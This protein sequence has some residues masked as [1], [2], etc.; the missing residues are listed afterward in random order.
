MASQGESSKAGNQGFPGTPRDGAPVEIIGLL[1]SS[2]RWV[3]ELS[4]KGAFPFSGVEATG[5]LLAAS[6][7]QDQVLTLA[8]GHSVDGKK[9]TVTY[10]E[11]ADL[12]QNSFERL[13][14]VPLG[15]FAAFRRL[16][17]PTNVDSLL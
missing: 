2:L 16:S 12:I 4:K 7:S 3:A 1:K 9:K 13:F 10:A 14:Y 17:L 8:F 5:A 11:W 15:A 6:H